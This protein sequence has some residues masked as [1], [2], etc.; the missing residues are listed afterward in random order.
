MEAP[1]A[2]VSA[3]PVL[4]DAADDVGFFTLTGLANDLLGAHTW[5]GQLAHESIRT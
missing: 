2:S 1:F 4:W 3:P 5:G